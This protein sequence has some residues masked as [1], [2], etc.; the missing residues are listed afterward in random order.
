MFHKLAFGLAAVLC[1]AGTVSDAQSIDTL[2]G[3]LAGFPMKLLGKI[4]SQSAG[5]SGQITRQTERYLANMARG[6]QQLQKRVAA[7]DSSGAATLFGNAQQHYAALASLLKTDTTRRTV[8][9]SGQYLPFADTLQGAMSFLQRNPHLLARAGSLSPQVNAKLQ[10]AAGQFQVLQAKLQDAD[11]VKAYVLSRQQ[12]ISQYLSQHTQFIGILG[13]RVSQIQ[14]ESYYY[15]QRVRQYKEMLSDPD[16]LTQ[17]A[18][19]MLTRLSVFQNFMKTH[20]QLGSLFQSPANYSSA[21]ALNGLQTKAQVAQVVQT[22]ISAA[23]PS[24]AA[25]LQSNL[26]AAQNQL[27]SYKDKLSKLGI[28][29]GDGQLPN[30]TPND[31]KTK[32]FLK[33]FQYGFNFQATHNSSFYPSLVSMGLSLGY[34]LG[35]SNVIGVG[36]AYELGTGNGIQHIAFSSNGLGLRTFLNLNIKKGFS[37]TGGLEYN[38]TT[39]FTTYQQLKEIRYWQRSGLI[40]VMKTVSTKSKLLK[41]TTLSLLWDFLSYQNAPPT[42]PFL[43]RLG[44]TL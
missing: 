29:N 7:T 8:P 1:L 3:R 22:K 11:I 32:T 37:A 25:A 2:T 4:R 36:A 21:Q 42:Q 40:G 5:L 39:P 33:R 31:Q 38:Y 17:K 12:Q 18:L 14:Q 24:G 9:L 26:Q 13:K 6:E 15:S 16:A 19:S 44:Y 30:F 43:F 20:S 10:A 28:G 27:D 34:K 35:H 41:Q 23:G